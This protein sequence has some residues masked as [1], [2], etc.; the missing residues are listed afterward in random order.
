MFSFSVRVSYRIILPSH[1]YVGMYVCIYVNTYMHTRL[2]N[3]PGN[4]YLGK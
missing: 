1:T 3:V 2:E 4:L